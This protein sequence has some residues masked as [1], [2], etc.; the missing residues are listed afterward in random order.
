MRHDYGLAKDKVG[1]FAVIDAKKGVSRE[2]HPLLT[3]YA[4]RLAFLLRK[5]LHYFHAYVTARSEVV[6]Y[7][8]GGCFGTDSQHA[9]NNIFTQ[10]SESRCEGKSLRKKH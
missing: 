7:Y 1:N 9:R 4:K 8:T 6:S 2:A 10:H 3:I 5:S